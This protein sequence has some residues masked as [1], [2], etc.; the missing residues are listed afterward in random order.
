MVMCKICLSPYKDELMRAYKQG[1][2]RKILWEKYNP[3]I[4]GG[5][6]K[7]KGVVFGA[8]LQAIYRH[9]KHGDSGVVVVQTKNTGIKRDLTGIVKMV[10]EL[11]SRKLET[12]GPEDI[13]VKDFSAANK[14]LLD[15]KKLKLDQN[16]QMIEL[17]K[18][19]GIP[20]VINPLDVIQGE[21]LKG[22]EK[23]AELRPP[24]DQ[25][26]KQISP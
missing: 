26:D 4:W 8:F 20:E 17:A 12:M 11:Y 1:F 23:D 18:L 25:G 3:L 16:E 22:E 5:L 24:E 13:S 6:G 10:N 9:G 21:D 7:R 2:P 15:E 19:F 14:L